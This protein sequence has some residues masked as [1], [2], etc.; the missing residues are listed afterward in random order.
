MLRGYKI[1]LFYYLLAIDLWPISAV[2]ADI[3]QSPP[4]NTTL[5]VAEVVNGTFA[6]GRKRLGREGPIPIPP[7]P[8]LD[9]VGERIRRELRRRHGSRGEALQLQGYRIPAEMVEL[10]QHSMR[11]F[12]SDDVPSRRQY[13]EKHQMERF[14]YYD[15]NKDVVGNKAMSMSQETI[16]LTQERIKALDDYIEDLQRRSGSPALFNIGYTIKKMKAILEDCYIIY[17]V[18]F[19]E[20][21]KENFFKYN[22]VTTIY[23]YTFCFK[24]YID[25]IYYV[26]AVMVAYAAVKKD[27]DD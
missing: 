18:L 2:A 22:V 24:K 16:Y 27:N 6:G 8:P 10:V 17:T 12:G 4:D 5:E 7:L 20:K 3:A 14:Y 15:E 23:Y 11:R 13:F 19:R 9:P 25:I 26:E 1:N 21:F